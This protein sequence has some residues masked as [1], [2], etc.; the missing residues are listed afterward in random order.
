MLGAG[1]QRWLKCAAARAVV[2]CPAARE[3]GP[4]GGCTR[5][6]AHAHACA[7]LQRDDPPEALVWAVCDAAGLLQVPRHQRV[8]AGVE[9][10]R[11]QL[12]VLDLDQVE[13]AGAAWAG[14]GSERQRYG[15]NLKPLGAL[16][17]GERPAP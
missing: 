10:G 7:H 8:A 6:T 14:V 12:G 16:G 15:D 1:W 4:G 17:S 13:Q 5:H 9:E 2:T 3:P 11:A